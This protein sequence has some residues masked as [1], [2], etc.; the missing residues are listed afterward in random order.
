[1][2]YVFDLISF[3]VRGLGDSLT[4]A[5]SDYAARYFVP[6]DLG[7]EDWGQVDWKAWEPDGMGTT[8][9][10]EYIDRLESCLLSHET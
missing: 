5:R 3:E 10:T 2:W 7:V 9:H 6:G 1:M 8:A 4:T